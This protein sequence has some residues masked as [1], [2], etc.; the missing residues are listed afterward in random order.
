M[1]FEQSELQRLVEEIIKLLERYSGD[2]AAVENLLSELKSLY[3]KIPIYPG[4][5]ARCLPLAVRPI[6][7]ERLKNGQ[8]VTICLKDNRILAGKVVN[9]S[10]DEVKLAEC[11]E[12][13]PP[14]SSGEITVPLREVREVRLLTRKVLQKEWPELDFRE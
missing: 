4:I 10:P 9:I 8:E 11:R 6:E 5:I 12:F 1:T 14:K 2:S 13:E 3:N 7:R